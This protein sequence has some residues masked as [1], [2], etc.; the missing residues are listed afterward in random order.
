[1]TNIED[2]SREQLIQLARNFAKNWLA[3]DG[4]WFQAVEA[5]HGMEEAIA[6]DAEAWRR[7]SPIEAKRIKEFLSL[8]DDGG[9][10]ALRTALDFRLYAMLNRQSS[11]LVDGV[12]RF[13]MN[14]CRVQSARN[15][16]GLPDFPCKEVGQVEYSTFAETID[17]RIETRCVC[18]PP[19]DHPD[20]CYCEW[21]FRLKSV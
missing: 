1:M 20:T 19:D 12:L 8:G 11:V 5:A 2:L 6:L 15:R 17:P 7:F 10:E 4:L 13:T 21:E 16:K 9:L 14:D 3:H 18:C